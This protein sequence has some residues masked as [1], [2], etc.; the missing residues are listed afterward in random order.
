[1]SHNNNANL[2][3]LISIAM[4]KLKRKM[5]VSIASFML[6][7]LIAN[8]LVKLWLLNEKKNVS[9]LFNFT[10]QSDI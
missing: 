3:L 5:I 2:N 1:M 10:K 7:I 8:V 4:K 9:M 6:K